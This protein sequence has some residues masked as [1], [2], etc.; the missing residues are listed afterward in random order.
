[1]FPLAM[2]MANELLSIPVA[3]ATLALGAAIVAVAAAVAGRTLN[4]ERLPLMGVIG[5]FVFAAQMIN[6]TLPGMPGTSGHLGGGVL[7]AVVLGPAAGI[8]TMAAILIVQCLLFQDGGVLALGCNIINM[9]LVPCLAGWGLYRL[10][11]GSAWKVSPWRQYLSVWVAC[12]VG[13]TAGAALV[14][15][16]AKISGVMQIPLSHFLV[17]M[18]GVHL[19]IGLFEG[20]ITFAVIAYLRLARPAA[21]GLAGAHPGRR[22]L[23]RGSVIVSVLLTAVLVAGAVSWFASTQPDGLEWS[24]LVRGYGQAESALKEPSGAVTG[25]ND[26]QSKWSLMPDYKMRA[27]PLG[28]AAAEPEEAAESDEAGWPAIDGWVSVAGLLGTAVTLAIV[29]LAA[30][31][32]RKRRRRAG[33]A[34]GSRP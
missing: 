9:G 4:P 8:V 14:P 3:A 25:A 19:L 27:A 31:L 17:V 22:R 28:A 18:V 10:L 11:L 1:M 30:V 6:F 2:H 5:A 16:Q 29:Y 34:T 26:W 24:Y 7:L 20:L 12:M 33:L 15:I 32:L 13:V 21:L 23:G